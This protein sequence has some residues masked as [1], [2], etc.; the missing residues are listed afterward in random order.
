MMKNT[1]L[2]AS[3]A[4]GEK[5]ARRAARE[6]AA[7]VVVDAY[8]ASTTIA[9]LVHKGAEVIPVASIE[10]AARLPGVDYR[11]GER[12]SAKVKGF[13]FGNSPME[14]RDAGI[15]PGATVVLSTTNGTR[16]VEAA[17]GASSIFTGAF[18]NA[19]AIADALTAGS[20][21][22]VFIVGCGWEG[23]RAS[24][25]E[26]AAGAILHRL[27]ERG[28]RLDERAQR[29]VGLYLSRPEGALR[30]NSA[31]RRLLRLGYAEDLDFCLAEDT[32]PAAPRLSGRTFAGD[33]PAGQK[34][35]DA[36]AASFAK[37]RLDKDPA[38]LYS[39]VGQGG[40]NVTSVLQA[41][42]VSKSPDSRGKEVTKR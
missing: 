20:H 24:E 21:D 37:N 32:V 3:Y 40:S 4:G 29:V 38:P 33:W 27:R 41:R 34:R 35:G 6:G 15:P 23:R 19:S 39:G 31:A 10:E 14:V 25:D 22:S 5:G 17:R 9:V 11:I 36:G 8:R 2:I 13:D 42:D 7:V 28:A 12:G 26:S 30:A 18:V 16:V 1:N